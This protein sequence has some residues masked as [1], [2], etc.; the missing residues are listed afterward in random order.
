M[1]WYAR[2]ETKSVFVKLALPVKDIRIQKTL[3]AAKNC[4]CYVLSFSHFLSKLA[5]LMTKN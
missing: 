3:E 5:C 4:W 1:K 2:P